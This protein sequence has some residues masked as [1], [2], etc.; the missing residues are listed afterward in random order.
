MVLNARWAK[1]G[2]KLAEHEKDL[3]EVRGEYRNYLAGREE[4]ENGHCYS[5]KSE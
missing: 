3:T 5:S 1:F 4:S 2:K